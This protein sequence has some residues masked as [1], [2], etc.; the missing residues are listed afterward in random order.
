MERRDLKEQ[1][2]AWKDQTSLNL[3]FFLILTFVCFHK[4]LIISTHVL[5]RCDPTLV[6]LHAGNSLVKHM[7]VAR[8][9]RQQDEGP[10]LVGAPALC[11]GQ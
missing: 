7:R 9:M 10:S 11:Q 4:W 8:Q 3:F 1:A 6:L 5:P 2:S